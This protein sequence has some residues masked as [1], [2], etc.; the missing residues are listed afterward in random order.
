MGAALTYARRY[1]LFTLVGIAGE[2][3]LDAPDLGVTRKP[4]ADK[5]IGSDGQSEPREHVAEDHANGSRDRSR[6]P[7][8]P[9]TLLEADASATLCDQLM[10]ELTAIAAAEEAVAWAQRSLPA[11]NTLTSADA[12]LI[13]KRCEAKFRLWK[14]R[15]MTATP[16]GPRPALVKDGTS[17]ERPKLAAMQGGQ[18]AV[19]LMKP[20]RKRDKSAS[21]LRVLAA[22]SHLR[23]ASFRRPSHP[24]WAAARPGEQ[25]PRGACSRG[26]SPSWLT[27]RVSHCQQ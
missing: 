15:K 11:K 25:R 26:L 12:D 2:D 16:L 13:G 19:A 21:R 23:S 1:A 14:E 27:A 10:E 4:E 7:R 8:T 18:N 5:P 9:K 20:I 3:D 17:S 6:L 24:G 22:L